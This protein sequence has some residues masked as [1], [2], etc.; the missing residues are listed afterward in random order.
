MSSMQNDVL[1]LA[2]APDEPS[3]GNR[4]SLKV[5][6]LATT[7]VGCGM[8]A[9][10]A[11]A[12]ELLLTTT[13]DI[14]SGTETGAL[15]GMP[16]ATTGLTGT[17]TLS[18]LYDY[19][20]PNYSATGSFASDF[21]SFPSVPGAV[22]ATVNGVPLSIG[23]SNSLGS[24]LEEDLVA[25][26]G[27][28]DASNA[29]YNGAASTGAFVAVSQDLVCGSS[30]SCVPA[31][32]LMTPFSYTLMAG[33]SGT[34]QYTFDCAGFPTCTTT[35]TFTGTETSFTFQVP[36]SPVPEPASWALLTTGLLGFGLFARRR[37]RG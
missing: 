26:F 23:L 31:A 14:T 20:G 32:D 4:I 30:N 16:A 5:L 12:G 1:A 17:Y 10:P 35:A 36:P 8:M 6:L 33:D 25:G 27:A 3:N 11:D 2:R 21:E 22:T 37:R 15:F 28:F 24:I 7:L 18:V 9:L 34:D 13:G 29:G 19:L